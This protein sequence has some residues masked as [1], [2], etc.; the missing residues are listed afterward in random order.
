[1]RLL[2]TSPAACAPSRTTGARRYQGVSGTIAVVGRHGRGAPVIAAPA[3]GGGRS[4]GRDRGQ[5]RR[6]G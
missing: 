4:D 6:P 3:N 1:M 2:P 5:H